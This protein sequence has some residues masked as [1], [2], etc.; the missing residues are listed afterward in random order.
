M[1]FAFTFLLISQQILA[2]Q[3]EKSLFYLIFLFLH[4]KKLIR[5]LYK[6]YDSI[7]LQ[8]MQ[9]FPYAA[10]N[11]ED[12]VETVP[13]IY[14]VSSWD[15]F[16]YYLKH[17]VV[18]PFQRQD[19]LWIHD[20]CGM[21]GRQLSPQQSELNINITVKPRKGKQNVETNTHHVAAELGNPL[22]ILD[23]SKC[24]WS[25][26]SISLQA[27]QKHIAN[28]AISTFRRNSVCFLH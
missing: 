24:V 20:L 19:S 12:Q 2:R 14:T 3:C 25:S 21:F 26:Q 17:L 13:C 7:F 8:G 22:C 28:T 16:P 9:T 4:V 11:L 6:K 23:F 15:Y 5:Y 27:P 10:S 1:S 18:T